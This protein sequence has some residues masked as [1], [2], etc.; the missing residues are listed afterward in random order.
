MNQTEA[1]EKATTML[2]EMPARAWVQ[3]D[4]QICPFC[5]SHDVE[6]QADLERM[7]VTVWQTHRCHTCKKTFHKLYTLNGYAD[8]AFGL[9]ETLH[10]D[11]TMT[12]DQ[13]RAVWPVFTA[14]MNGEAVEY[15]RKRD[16]QPP[17]TGWRT[18]RDFVLPGD[19]RYEYRVKPLELPVPAEEFVKSG[20]A[21]CPYCRSEDI[22]GQ[23]PTSTTG[24]EAWGK[25]RCLTCS[26][27]WHEIY[28]LV[29]YEHVEGTGA[30]GRGAI[31]GWVLSNR[32]DK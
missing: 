14:F 26:E 1:K 25:L 27:V 9:T 4:G 28:T 6:V 10:G 16:E 15:R 31:E 24:N 18:V 20:A 23:G 8:E 7:E 19:S 2:L 30:R 12:R 13:A 29:G 3:L 11:T 21:M 32:I 22:T 17:N 5:R